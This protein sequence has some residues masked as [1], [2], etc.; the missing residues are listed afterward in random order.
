MYFAGAK[1]R[2]QSLPRRTAPPSWNATNA[3]SRESPAPSRKFDEAIRKP[4]K[5]MV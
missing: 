2:S 3:K 1:W 4:R 5:E